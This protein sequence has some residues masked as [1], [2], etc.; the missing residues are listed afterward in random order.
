MNRKPP[1][2]KQPVSR[3][4]SYL[5]GLASGLFLAFLY[6]L[7]TSQPPPDAPVADL[8][9]VPAQNIEPKTER[10]DWSFYDLFPKAEVANVGGYQRAKRADDPKPTYHLQAGSFNT[11]RDADERRA[12]LLLLGLTAFIETKPIDGVTWHRVMIGPFDSDTDL[13]RAQSLLAANNF[14]SIPI[15]NKP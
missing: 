12:E 6:S 4:F 9:P 5:A 7:V 15:S 1:A 14:E 10:I 2:S 13:G 3:L 8:E 11:P